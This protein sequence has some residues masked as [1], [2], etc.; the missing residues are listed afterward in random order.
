VSLKGL[1]AIGGSMLGNRPESPAA[2]F[3]GKLMQLSASSSCISSLDL[4][5]AQFQSRL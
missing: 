1:P 4:D 2:R 5:P 3:V